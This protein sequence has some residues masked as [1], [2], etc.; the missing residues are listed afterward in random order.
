MNYFDELL[1]S[2]TK[3]KKRTF[4]IR[5]NESTDEIPPALQQDLANAQGATFEAPYMTQTDP[6]V[7]M[8]RTAKGKITVKDESV[9]GRYP[10]PLTDPAGNFVKP[11]P[12]NWNAILKLYGVADGSL[13]DE[14]QQDQMAA[15]TLPGDTIAM[16]PYASE[17]TMAAIQKIAGLMI[18]LFGEL[19]K[20]EKRAGGFG[21]SLNKF[22]NYFVGGTYQSFERKISLADSLEKLE[23]GEVLSVP[24]DKT[25]VEGVTENFANFL[26]TLTKYKIADDIKQNMASVMSIGVRGSV[27]IHNKAGR[28]EGLVFRDETGILKT[29]A[30]IAKR[31]FEIEFETFDETNKANAASDIAL[32]GLTLEG[33]IPV[34]TSSRHCLELKKIAPE[35]SEGPCSQSR[36]MLS[37]L[38]PQMD[39]YV[40]LHREWAQAYASGMKAISLED[41]ELA[42]AI[43]ETLGDNMRD[44]VQSVIGISKGTI[45]IRKPDFAVPVGGTAGIGMSTD[46]VEGWSDPIKARQGLLNQ[47][48]SDEEILTNNMITAA[49]AIKV[50]MTKPELLDSLIKSGIIKSANDTIFYSNVNLKNYLDLNDGKL[51]QS[52]VNNLGNFFQKESNSPFATTIQRNLGINPKQWRQIQDYNKQIDAMET[53]VRNLPIHATTRTEDGENLTLSPF[54]QS[55]TTMIDNLRK[56]STYSEIVGTSEK[57]ELIQFLDNFDLESKDG[58][59]RAKEYLARYLR[60]KK[61]SKDIE[62]GDSTAKAYF[63]AQ[64]GAVAGSESD[65]QICDWRALK[66][67]EVFNFKQNEAVMS[68]LRDW[69]AGGTEWNLKPS[70]KFTFVLENTENPFKKMTIRMEGRSMKTNERYARLT[71]TVVNFS[72]DM[73]KHFH[74][75]GSSIQESNQKNL[76]DLISNHQKE[77]FS[78]LLNLGSKN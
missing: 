44:I 72:K 65:G 50:F 47:G 67:G 9:L 11:K 54:K 28:E 6:P 45:A 62:K 76:L 10:I 57:G 17:K 4:K 69:L 19:T 41:Q 30:G 61:L 20:D 15:M 68:P 27:V 64:V 13:E 73:L 8:W 25:L 29:I 12:Q 24:I 77:L 14:P 1:E 33:L 74:R 7:P 66:T 70:G 59:E 5:L 32:R 55:A 56:N 38:K 53:R 34:L 49:P 26:D 35:I 3:L 2:Y 71:N 75:K 46:I 58:A 51:G 18:P 31:K 22:T 63:A 39:K 78:L 48:Y 42:E 43:I 52:L 16:S 21:K 37:Q 23:T 40:R 60:Y 36:D